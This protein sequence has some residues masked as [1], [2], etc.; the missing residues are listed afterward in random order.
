MDLTV[1]FL[2]M[3]EEDGD[4]CD[5]DVEDID[6]EDDDDERVLSMRASSSSAWLPPYSSIMLSLRFCSSAAARSAR[7]LL[8]SFF[9]R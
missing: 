9:A 5:C 8:M 2:V 4:D 1:L 7:S 3:E 6:G